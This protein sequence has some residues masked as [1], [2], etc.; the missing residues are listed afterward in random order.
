MQN[1]GTNYSFSIIL[2]IANSTLMCKLAYVKFIIPLK[3]EVVDRLKK[4][5]DDVLSQGKSVN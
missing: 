2:P 5:K 1:P 3:L 4:K